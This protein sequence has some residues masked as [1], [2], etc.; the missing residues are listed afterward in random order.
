MWLPDHGSRIW[1]FIFQAVIPPIVFVISLVLMAKISYVIT[2]HDIAVLDRIFSAGMKPGLVPLSEGWFRFVVGNI[3]CLSVLGVAGLAAIE[4][5]SLTFLGKKRLISFI[6]RFE[7]LW[8]YFIVDSQGRPVNSGGKITLRNLMTY[9]CFYG[10]P[11]TAAIVAGATKNPV[12]AAGVMGLW[13]LYW[14]L[15]VLFVEFHPKQRALHDTLLKL[16]KLE[17]SPGNVANVTDQSQRYPVSE[18]TLQ[19]SLS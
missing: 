12:F 19:N 2:T 11:L 15:Q 10:G 1:A 18:L 8:G 4:M 5:F 16:W 13:I 7:R 6:P 14:S 9:G 17:T 3:L